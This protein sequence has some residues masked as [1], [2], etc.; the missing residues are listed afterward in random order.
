MSLVELIAAC[1]ICG[2]ICAVIAQRK[3]LNPTNYFIAGALL[4]LIG[5]AI[6]ALAKPELPEA[7]SGMFAAKCV[8]C[9]AVQNVP[10]NAHEFECWQCHTVE[11][12]SHP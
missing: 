2:V 5:V 8:R 12:I 9:N 4:G 10:I 11:T 3:N 1:L 6:T 7:P